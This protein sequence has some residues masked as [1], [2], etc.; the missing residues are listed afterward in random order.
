MQDVET[1]FG[2]YEA[3]RSRLPKV[4]T[5]GATRETASLL[6]IVGEVDAFVFDAFGVLNV[7][8]T[9]I[10]GADTR[11][12]ELRSQ[13]CQIRILT[14]AASYDRTHALGKFRRLGVR[15]K[16]DEIITS[17]DAALMSLQNLRWGVIAAPDD[18]L[19]DIPFRWIR[20]EDEASAYSDVEGFL[21]LSSSGWTEKR[22]TILASA[23]NAKPRPLVVANPDLVAPR[24]NGF[25]LEPGY[26]GHRIADQHP[27][28]VSFYG[29]PFP[30][31]YDLVEKTL[32]GIAPSRIA[33]C[34]DTL[35]TDI[36]GAAARGWQTVLVTR[37]GLFAG[38]D[39]DAFAAR[40]GIFADWRLARI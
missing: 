1:I 28:K 27:D 9:L 16:D 37:D 7:G 14:N 2:R 20:L 23:M 25:S 33:M 19:V 24:D 22:Q 29:K 6:D 34:G 15:V 40:A 21:F 35:H 31:A 5:P 26:Y 4:D 12:D 11:L 39:T 8:D 30:E 3:V 38:F 36:I 18:H 10:D 17:R 32:P 13:G